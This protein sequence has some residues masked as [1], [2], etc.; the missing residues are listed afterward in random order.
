[1]FD[2]T[3]NGISPSDL[4]CW[5]ATIPIITPSQVIRTRQTVVGM[6]GELLGTDDSYGDAQIDFTIHAKST[7]LQAISRNIRKWLTGTGT[8]VISDHNDS[9]Y[10]VKEVN[11]TTYL[12]KDEAY[13][14][15]AVSMKVYPYEFLN[16]GE[17]WIS[18]FPISNTAM[19]CKP[20]Y[21]I[22]GSS[23]SAQGTL[24]VR[25]NTI[26][27]TV[28]GRGADQTIYIDTRRKITYNA[29][30]VSREGYIS[31]DYEDLWLPTGSNAISATIGSVSVKTRWGYRI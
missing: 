2:I 11:Y 7:T 10:E 6:D 12:K 14:R 9:F 16:S 20:L 25:G 28:G 18:S 3:Y 29:N 1:M 13:G 4:G 5:L 24:T 27:Y 31:G 22:V 19:L 26:T 21:R 17:E 23:S 8:L 30:G 15:I